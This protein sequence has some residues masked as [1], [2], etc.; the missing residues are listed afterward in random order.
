MSDSALVGGLAWGS[1][2]L[3]WS[4]GGLFFGISFSNT[5][6]SGT[7]RLAFLLTAVSGAYVLAS[8]IRSISFSNYKTSYWL[9]LA[10]LLGVGS[11]RQRANFR[12][13]PSSNK[14]ETLYTILDYSELWNKHKN[15]VS[16]L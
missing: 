16:S 5:S 3:G 10:T 6:I 8:L 7:Y 2:R 13:R 9:R 15:P 11:K 1:S 14:S 4:V 12:P